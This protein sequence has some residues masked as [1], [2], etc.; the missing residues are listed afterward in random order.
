MTAKISITQSQW[1]KVKVVFRTDDFEVRRKRGEITIIT[2]VATR[3][4][5]WWF[6]DAETW[7]A[8]AER[9]RGNA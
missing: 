4:R 5:I 3:D 7:R 2:D 1:E 9:E 8:A 6:C